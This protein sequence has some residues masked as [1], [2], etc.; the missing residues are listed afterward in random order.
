MKSDARVGYDPTR[1]LPF[2]RSAI[3]HLGNGGE[4]ETTRCPTCGR[5]FDCC[6]GRNC[7]CEVKKMGEGNGMG[8]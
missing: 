6:C 3:A 5:A 7:P 8:I 2:I 4:E 1:Q